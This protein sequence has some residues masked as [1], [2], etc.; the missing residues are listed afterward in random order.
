MAREN[1]QQ[2]AIAFFKQNLHPAPN[3][4]GMA[5]GASRGAVVR[6][7]QMV[8]LTNGDLRIRAGGSSTYRVNV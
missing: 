7:G 4:M 3:E 5:G 2:T 1:K 8:L 6:Y